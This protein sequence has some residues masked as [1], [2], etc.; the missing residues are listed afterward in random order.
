VP[1]TAFPNDRTPVRERDQPS[2]RR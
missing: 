2:R 1:T